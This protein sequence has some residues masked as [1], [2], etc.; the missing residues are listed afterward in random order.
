MKLTLLPSILR[1]VTLRQPFFRLTFL[2]LVGKSPHILELSLD[3]NTPLESSQP[4]PSLTVLSDF[5]FKGDLPEGKTS[6]SNIL[7]S[8]EELIV[9]SL[10]EIRV[11]LRTHFSKERTT[12]GFSFP[13]H[14]RP[15]SLDTTLV[16]AFL[17]YFKNRSKNHIFRSILQKNNRELIELHAS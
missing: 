16:F 7:A 12:F 11:R 4:G 13:S 17:K 14:I 2:D 15:T 8:C 6:E 3:L 1:Q 5:L 10:A 9:E